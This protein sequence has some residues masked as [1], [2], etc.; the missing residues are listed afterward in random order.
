MMKQ[1]SAVSLGSAPSVERFGVVLSVSMMARREVLPC[2]WKGRGEEGG[3][4]VARVFR[5]EERGFMRSRVV[6]G[7]PEREDD[8]GIIGVL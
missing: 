2:L 8:V 3:F 1:V 5:R 6:L 4:G 7:V